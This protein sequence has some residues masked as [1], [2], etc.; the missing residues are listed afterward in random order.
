L[1]DGSPDAG[2]GPQSSKQCEGGYGWYKMHLC[3]LGIYRT[4]V[5]L[6][7]KASINEFRQALGM[8]LSYS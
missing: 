3:L 1:D 2:S 7:S 5:Y 8:F 4:V 6:D